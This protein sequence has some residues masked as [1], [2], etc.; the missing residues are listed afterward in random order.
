MAEPRVA[1]P[2]SS[3]DLE[4]DSEPRRQ[5]AHAINRFDDEFTRLKPTNALGLLYTTAAIGLTTIAILLSFSGKWAVWGLGQLLLAFSLL[6]WFAM[7]HEAGH[8]TLFRSSW[9]NQG[10]GYLAGFFALIPFPCWKIA[11]TSKTASIS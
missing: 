1:F 6:H 2:Q 9:A 3:L 10:V 8:R 4:R 5:N 11:R 7:I